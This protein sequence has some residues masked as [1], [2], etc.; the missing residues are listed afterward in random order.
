VAGE[1]GAT[2]QQLGTSTVTDRR[3]DYL[4]AEDGEDQEATLRS[5][6]ERPGGA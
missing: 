4:T 5:F 1:R 2:P 6:T 3:L